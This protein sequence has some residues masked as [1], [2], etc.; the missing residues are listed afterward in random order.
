MVS[1]FSNGVN[2]HGS[3]EG[4]VVER[5]TLVYEVVALGTRVGVLEVLHDARLAERVEALCHGGGVDEV[6]VADLEEWTQVTLCIDIKIRYN[7]H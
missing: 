5:V 4:Y 7:S 1:N 2:L 6:A 3:V